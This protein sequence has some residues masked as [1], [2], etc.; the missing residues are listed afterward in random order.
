LVRLGWIAACL[1]RSS[2]VQ[3]SW[4]RGDAVVHA[5]AGIWAARDGVTAWAAC[6]RRR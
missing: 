1:C 3:V 4:Q 6:G 2:A 5:V